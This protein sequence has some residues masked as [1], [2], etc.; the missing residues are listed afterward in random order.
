MESSLQTLISWGSRLYWWLVEK[1]RASVGEIEKA[2]T[3]LYAFNST[4]Y[5]YL[6]KFKSSVLNVF[7]VGETL[8]CSS[9]SHS[10]DYS[11]VFPIL[12]ATTLVS[13]EEEISSGLPI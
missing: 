13:I 4:E 5:R 2:K 9:P 8:V 11:D 12:Y 1:I 10:S 7:L 6:V 3:F